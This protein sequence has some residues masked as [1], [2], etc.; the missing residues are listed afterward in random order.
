MWSLAASARSYSLQ[1]IRASYRG[2]LNSH[3]IITLSLD[4]PHN[5]DLQFRSLGWYG[6]TGK[7]V[8]EMK[9]A[10]RVGLA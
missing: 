7:K 2:G 6:G 8:D 4:K 1:G 5:L 10:I 9:V 3:L